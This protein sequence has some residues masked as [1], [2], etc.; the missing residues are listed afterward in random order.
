MK[1]LKKFNED[2]TVRNFSDDDLELM[3][4]H[5]DDES[6]SD[7]DLTYDKLKHDI[8]LSIDNMSGDLEDYT[9]IVS[10]QIIIKD[11]ISTDFG[12]YKYEIKINRIG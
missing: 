7:M 8:E 1:Y 3:K 9:N 2:Q 4:S 11:D 10:S 5:M 12:K 6:I